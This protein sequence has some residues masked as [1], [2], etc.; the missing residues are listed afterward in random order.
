MYI[1]E[2]NDSSQIKLNPDISKTFSAAST[3]KLKANIGDFDQED[4]LT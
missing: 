1:S 2:E 4:R 3:F